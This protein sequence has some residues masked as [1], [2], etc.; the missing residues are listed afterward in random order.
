M[1]GLSAAPLTDETAVDRRAQAYFSNSVLLADS[2]KRCC[3]TNFD[4]ITLE[5]KQ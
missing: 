4:S 5:I 3:S 1:T 2:Q